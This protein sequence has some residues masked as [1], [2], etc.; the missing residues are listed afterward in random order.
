MPHSLTVWE[1]AHRLVD[2]LAQLEATDDPG[3]SDVTLETLSIAFASR[4]VVMARIEETSVRGVAVR[5]V[6]LLAQDLQQ[7]EVAANELPWLRDEGAS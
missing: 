7:A 3:G 4:I 2:Y 1:R 5:A 6:R